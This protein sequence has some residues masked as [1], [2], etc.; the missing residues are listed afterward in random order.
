MC[1]RRHSKGMPKVYHQ[2]SCVIEPICGGVCMYTTMCDL[3]IMK[4]YRISWLKGQLCI[5]FFHCSL[6]FFYGGNR[7]VVYHDE[8]SSRLSVASLMRLRADAERALSNSINPP[9][10]LQG[11]RLPVSSIDKPC[12][13]CNP[14]SGPYSSD[15]HST[16]DIALRTQSS[17]SPG[18]KEYSDLKKIERL[19]YILKGGAFL[20]AHTCF[21]VFK[22]SQHHKAT[23][24]T[25]EVD[26]RIRR[27]TSKSQWQCLGSGHYERESMTRLVPPALHALTGSNEV[28]ESK[29]LDS[30]SRLHATFDAI[31]ALS[32][33]VL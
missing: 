24:L 33:N 28:T 26:D 7:S 21:C 23:A 13:S 31:S 8:F 11:Q 4:L 2:V 14:L 1:G 5:P 3:H 27:I 32:A 25:S 17:S 22:M 12:S 29:G 9:V 15:N 30:L 18:R 6:I 20:C 10:G 19:Q 16:V